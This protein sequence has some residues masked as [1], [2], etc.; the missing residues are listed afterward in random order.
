LSVGLSVCSG[1][2]FLRETLDALLGQ[3]FLD[4]ELIISDDAS[5]GAT[6]KICR[7]YSRRDPRIRYIRQPSRIGAGPNRDVL[8]REARGEYFTW[9]SQGHRYEPY[10]FARCIDVLDGRPDAVVCH[11]CGSPR[12]HT[13][14]PP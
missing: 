2:S 9:V 14:K 4:F 11:R 13:R 10:L 3:S 5:T 7:E 1:Q 6:E 12:Q 8:L